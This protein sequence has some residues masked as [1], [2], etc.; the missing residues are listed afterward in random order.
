M[1]RSKRRECLWIL[2]DTDEHSPWE[3]KYRFDF[4]YIRSEKMRA[5]IQD[6]M[7]H[8][9][10]NGDKAL[11]TLRQENSWLKYYE[12]FLY[13]R[14]IDSFFDISREDA[15]GF[16]TFLHTCVSGKT[17][18]PLRLIT[19]KHIYDT[20]RGVYRWYAVQ[21]TSDMAVLQFF[22][23]DVYQQINRI[24]RSEYVSNDEVTQFLQ[25]MKNTKN[26]CLHCGST[27]LA[28]TGLAPADLLGLRTDCIR[29]DGENAYLHY[30]HHRKGTYCTVPVS[31]VC[32][33]AVK[34]LKLRTDEL[35]RIAPK[36]KRKQLFLCSRKQGQV[37]TPGP[38]QFRYWMRCA[39]MKECLEADE[40]LGTGAKQV[41]EKPQSTIMTA[42]R[43]RSALI[44]DMQ[45]QMMPYM[46]I[47]ELIGH[48][49]LTERGSIA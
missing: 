25:L 32:V 12:A 37:T 22:P 46:V 45:E 49:L 30:Y 1:R 24:T 9:Y 6:Y 31:D 41:S 28:V 29:M 44:R 14:G 42:G 23:R 15:E 38:E 34:K 20:V 7:W 26:P 13:E 8:H 3:R 21:K 17:N 35:R 5:E 43:L 47:Q 10:R 4:S 16:L 2:T 36:E 27:I 48:P 18:Q 39:Q 40:S 11:T 19:Q 33:R